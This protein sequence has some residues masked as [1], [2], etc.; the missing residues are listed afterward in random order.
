MGEIQSFI[1]REMK[2]YEKCG[3]ISCS[4]STR[5]LEHEKMHIQQTLNVSFKINDEKV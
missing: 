5:K 1:K 2:I 3:K 4:S